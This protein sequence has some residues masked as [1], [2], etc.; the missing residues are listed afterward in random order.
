[1]RGRGSTPLGRAAASGSA[2]GKPTSRLAAAGVATGAGSTPPRSPPTTP[3]C[4]SVAA[5]SPACEGSK[6]TTANRWLRNWAR[7]LLAALR[8]AGVATS[9]SASAPVT[10]AASHPRA[11]EREASARLALRSAR[12]VP[13]PAAGRPRR[14]GRAAGL[15]WVAGHRAAVATRSRAASTCAACSGR[16]GASTPVAAAASSALPRSSSATARQAAQPSTWAPTAA[17]SAAAPSIQARSSPSS[18]HLMIRSLLL[19]LV[20]VAERAFGAGQQHAD[21]PD[22]Q[23]AGVGDLG[24]GVAGVAQQQAGP[25]PFGKRP[26][27]PVHRRLLFEPEQRPERVVALGGDR[28]LRQLCRGALQPLASAALAP[29]PVVAE[30]HADPAEPGLDLLVGPVDDG[31]ADQPEERLLH[32]VLGLPAVDEL[33]VAEVVQP[34]VEAA[35]QLVEPSGGVGSTLRPCVHPH[36]RRS[37]RR[38]RRPFRCRPSDETPPRVCF[39]HRAGQRLA[40]L[41]SVFRT[42]VGS[43][44][45]RF[46]T[47]SRPMSSLLSVSAMKATVT[48]STQTGLNT[49]PSPGAIG[50]LYQPRTPSGP[51]RPRKSWP[52]PGSGSPWS[53]TASTHAPSGLTARLVGR[54]PPG[55]VGSSSS[56]TPSVLLVTST[57]C[58]PLCV[59]LSTYRREESALH[60]GGDSR[61]SSEVGKAAEPGCASHSTWSCPLVDRNAIQR[62]SG[63]QVGAALGLG[64]LNPM[65]FGSWLGSG[66]MV[67][68]SPPRAN[69]TWLASVTLDRWGQ[70]SAIGRRFR[71]Q[72]PPPWKLS[73]PMLPNC[74]PSTR[75]RTCAVWISRLMVHTS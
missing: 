13:G 54:M 20:A 27:R 10:A 50:R 52:P 45:S 58:V 23:L 59:L 38:R 57:S 61:P 73:R 70:R 36:H 12:R 24:V 11:G 69:S 31:R 19:L 40:K 43:Q 26:Q 30:V 22:G 53:A 42:A 35:E 63:D 28:A 71:C 46:I 60:E 44:P 1:M 47:H 65:T 72:R 3:S 6:V 67:Q 74:R 39:L 17:W 34:R 62:W 16:A 68:I 48:A 66:G 33:P 75:M 9:T 25:L 5:G 4:R 64:A 41:G 21:R 15:L 29:Q 49:L 14:L 18:R 51:N 56:T 7:K 32:H 55:S 2:T 37:L 8:P